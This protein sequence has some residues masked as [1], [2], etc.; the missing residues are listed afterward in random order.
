MRPRDGE[1]ASACGTAEEGRHAA[2]RNASQL[3]LTLTR[4]HKHAKTQRHT[5]THTDLHTVKDVEA[6]E[7]H[8][9]AAD[10]DQ[11]GGEHMHTHTHTHTYSHTVKDVVGLE[12][13]EQHGGRLPRSGWR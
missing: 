6:L 3:A 9:G 2:L 7:Q 4:T 13:L 11:V 8:S 12:A 1:V 10:P 5:R